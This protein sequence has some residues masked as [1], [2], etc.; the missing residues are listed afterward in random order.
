[1]AGRVLRAQEKTEVDVA[2]QYKLKLSKFSLRFASAGFGILLKM[3]LKYQT[4]SNVKQ[5]RKLAVE[6]PGFIWVALYMHAYTEK[7]VQCNMGNNL[8][9]WNQNIE[10]L[11]W[12]FSCGMILDKPLLLL[13]A[14]LHLNF[15]GEWGY[16]YVYTS[17]YCSHIIQ[18][19]IVSM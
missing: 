1:M 5:K 2:V 15:L 6:A 9:I 12:T 4:P 14:F 7:E 10:F 18:Y 17:L 13:G 8:W 3:T 19:F 11:L 16:I